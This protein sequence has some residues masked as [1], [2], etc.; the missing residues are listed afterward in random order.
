MKRWKP[1]LAALLVVCGIIAALPL[2]AF[3]APEQ[4]EKALEWAQEIAEDDTHGYDKDRRDGP[5]YDCS[6]FVSYAL[7]AAG[8]ELDGPLST[9]TMKDALVG[10]GFKAYR[11]GEVKPRRGDILLDPWRH[12]EFYLGKQHCLAAHNDFD[13]RSGDSSGKEINVRDCQ[14][15]RFCRTRQYTW[16]LRWIEPEPEPEPAPAI[17]KVI[18]DL[19]SGLNQ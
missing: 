15:C 4:I 3:A 7:M 2:Q 9:C 6:S 12:V 5:N 10:L 19:R 17:E 1:A 11:R 18:P 8:F 14:G 16:I 13:Y